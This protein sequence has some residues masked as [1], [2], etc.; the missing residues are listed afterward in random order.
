MIMARKAKAKAK[1]RK[2]KR[3]ATRKRVSPRALRKAAGQKAARPS[4]SREVLEEVLVHSAKASEGD[5]LSDKALSEIA[6]CADLDP[7]RVLA[8]HRRL[9]E[10]AEDAGVTVLR[11]VELWDPYD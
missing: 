8:A 2:T 9:C 4:L 6:V 1:A 7:A 10:E 5:Q 3:K 11:V